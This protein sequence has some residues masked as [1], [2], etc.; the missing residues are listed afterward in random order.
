MT[1]FKQNKFEPVLLTVSNKDNDK[2]VRLK[3]VDV[4]PIVLCGRGMSLGQDPTIILCIT[5]LKAL[6]YEILFLYLTNDHLNNLRCFV[7]LSKDER[8]YKLFIVNIIIFDI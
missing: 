3:M 1:Q 5:G 4:N 6:Y 8:Y 7:I 2:L